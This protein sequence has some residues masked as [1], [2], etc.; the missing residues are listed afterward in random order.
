MSVSELHE[1]RET[2]ES[3]DAAIATFKRH[4]GDDNGDVLWA[5]RNEVN[6]A[7]LRC[8]FR[9]ARIRGARKRADATD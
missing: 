3:L 9:A 5:L 1:D 6:L 2:I 8:I 7:L 4:L